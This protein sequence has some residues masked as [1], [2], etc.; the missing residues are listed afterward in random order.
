MGQSLKGKK[1]VFILI[2]KSGS[3][4]NYTKRRDAVAIKHYFNSQ[5]SLTEKYLKIPDFDQ[6]KRA[7]EASYFMRF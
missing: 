1:K 4:A 7:E 3:K 2:T 5:F 6:I